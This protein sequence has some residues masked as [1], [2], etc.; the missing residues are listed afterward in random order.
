M[1]FKV[2]D[3]KGR[4]GSRSSKDM[5]LGYYGRNAQFRVSPPAFEFLGEPDKV[6]I[7]F[8]E[9]ARKIGIRASTEPHAVSLRA[10]APESRSRY[11]GFRA[12][13]TML[14]LGQDK[15]TIALTPSED[16]ADTLEG[17]LPS[18]A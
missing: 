4:Q 10:E 16:E 1:A 2:I 6:E 9:D 13:A 7:L 8:D 18:A 12:L 17:T 11:F 15:A 3:A 14:G 5:E